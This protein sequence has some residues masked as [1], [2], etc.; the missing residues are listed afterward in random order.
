M[1]ETLPHEMTVV[2]LPQCAGSA[3]STRVSLACS[4]KGC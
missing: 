4:T 3:A 1:S 2:P